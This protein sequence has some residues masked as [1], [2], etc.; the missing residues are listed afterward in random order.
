MMPEATR[1]LSQAHAMALANIGIGESADGN[2]RA[3]VRAMREALAYAEQHLPDDDVIFWI[4]S[5]LGSYLFDDGD[6]RGALEMAS[7]AL[8]YCASVRA[9]LA[10]L[11]MAKSFLR[12][13][14]LVRAREYAQ[15]ACDLRGGEVLNAFSSVDQQ[16]LGLAAP[17]QKAE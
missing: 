11:T 3:A 8:A 9:P 7:S 15:Q 2:P 13:G 12:L 4:Q 14:D 16:A 5:G 10:S 1:E 17:D 6:Y